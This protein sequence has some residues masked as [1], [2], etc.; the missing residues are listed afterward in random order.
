MRE[1][2]IPEDAKR[3]IKTNTECE[4]QT[5]KKVEFSTKNEA[6]EPFNLCE[7]GDR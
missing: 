2:V 7:K 4:V 1:Y 5:S 6:Q 3:E